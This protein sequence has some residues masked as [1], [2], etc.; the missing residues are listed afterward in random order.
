MLNKSKHIVMCEVNVTDGRT[1]RQ[2]PY[3]NIARQYADAR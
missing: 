2:N 1:D 3:I